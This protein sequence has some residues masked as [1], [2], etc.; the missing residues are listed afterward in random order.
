[1]Q[2]HGGLIDAT[3]ARGV[4]GVLSGPAGGVIGMVAAVAGV[5]AGSA[6]ASDRRLIGLDMGGTSTD[7]SLY[8]RRAAAPTADRD[9]RRADPG[10]DDGCA[11]D[12]GGWR[13]D[14]ALSRRPAA[15]WTGLRRRAPRARVLRPRRSGNADGLQRRAGASPARTVPADL[16]RGCTTRRSMPSQ[17]R[18]RLA[19]ILAEI[20]ADT[21]PDADGLHARE[22]SPARSSTSRTASMANAVRELALRHGED[23]T[24]FAL[25]C[26]G[27][28]SGQHACAIAEQLDID[29]ILLH[30]LVRRAL[31]IRYRT[32]PSRHDRTA[33]GRAAARAGAGAAAS[34]PSRTTPPRQRLACSSDKASPAPQSRRRCVPR[35][36]YRIPTLRSRFAGTRPTAMR[37]EFADAHARLFGLTLAATPLVVAAIVAEA[38]E[39]TPPDPGSLLSDD[40]RRPRA[41]PTQGDAR[42][43]R[44]ESAAVWDGNACVQANVF[45]RADLRAGTTLRGPALVAETGATI[46]IAGGWSG[47]VEETGVLVLRRQRAERRRRTGSGST[48]CDPRRLEVFNG[49]YHAHRRADG[50][51][52]RA[53]RELRQ[54]QGASRLLVR[55]LRRRR[56]ARRQ[57]TAHAGAPGLDGR[58]RR[59]RGRALRRTNCAAAMPT[60]STRRMPAA[61]TCPT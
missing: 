18:Q 33:H 40:G 24:Q 37:A 36:G 26:F 39:R 13:L 56:S 25:V 34:R 30:P 58:E 57:R 55:D 52:A 16:R 12:R 29:E 61:R 6:T 48:A 5:S 45:V 44:A 38:T 49:L 19:A 22:R 41:G 3:A 2:S 11:H 1:M 31:G 28:A 15:R 42:S 23:A 60:S 8:A 47:R 54:H 7:V 14:R 21:P 50:G 35:C 9:R 43:R 17:S 51:G 59:G 20:A 4:N 10:A 27:G 53:H 46:W 32:R